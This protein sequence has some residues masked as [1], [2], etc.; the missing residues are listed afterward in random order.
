M[1]QI[2]DATARVAKYGGDPYFERHC[3]GKRQYP[4]EKDARAAAKKLHKA[5]KRKFDAYPCKFCEFWHIGGR[6]KPKTQP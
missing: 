2:A 1:G 4:S 6:L 5:L 3:H